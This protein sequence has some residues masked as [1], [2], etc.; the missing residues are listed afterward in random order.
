MDRGKHT[1]HEIQSQPHV[2]QHALNA[3]SESEDH[4]LQLIQAESPTQVIVTG[5]GSTH[6]LSMIGARLLRKS[7]INAQAYPASELWLYPETV[8]L[9]DTTYLMIAVSRSGTTTETLRAVRV[10]QQDNHGKVITVTC[11]RTSPLAGLADVVFAINAAQ[12]ESVAQT[13]SFSSMCVVLQQ[14]AAALGE[15]DLSASNDLPEV[16]QTL[17]NTHEDL[18]KSLGENASIKKFFF[19]GSGA[20]YGLACEA[21]LKMKEMSLS[22]SEAFHMLEFRHG[23]M[24]MVAQDSLVVGLISPDSPEHDIKVLE[25]MQ[26]MGATVVA[27]GQTATEFE[28]KIQLPADLPAWTT[29]ILYLPILQ[30]MGYYRSLFNGQNPDKPHNLTAVISLD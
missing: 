5:C 12:E 14:M 3:Y 19:L 20:L 18:A 8:Y 28:H 29:P 16:C 26:T 11:D 17:L 25:E 4:F 10:F 24:S 30:L 13:R 21:M 9:P 6:Y 22:Y 23:P 7:G 27:M 2:W 15:H 1:L